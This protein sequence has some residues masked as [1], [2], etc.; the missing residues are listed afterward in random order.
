LIRLGTSGWSYDDWIGP[1]YPPDLPKGGWLPYLADKLDT[2][3]VNATYYRIPSQRMVEGWVARTPDA[4][5][6]AVKAHRSLT[7]DRQEPDF[8]PFRESLQPLIEAGK[9]GCI[10]AQFP[11]SFHANQTNAGYLSEIRGGLDGLPVVVEFRNRQWIH[12]KTFDLLRSLELGYCCVDEPHFKNLIPPVAQA[13]GPVGYVRFHGRNADKWWQHEHAWERYDYTYSE[14]ELEG[15]VP[16]LRMLEANTEVTLAYAN[17][18]YRGQALDTV[19]KLR[20]LLDSG[21]SK[22]GFGA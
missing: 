17:N 22:G 1:V 19:R 18:H 12:D 11:F 2:L 14:A 3:E 20:S 7:H 21:A 16:K 9:L 8:S 6:F 4:F 15:W 5:Q 13:T 10:L